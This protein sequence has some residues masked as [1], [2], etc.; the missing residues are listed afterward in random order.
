[1]MKSVKVEAK[2]S[3]LYHSVSCLNWVSEKD[4]FHDSSFFLVFELN[5]LL[6]KNGSFLK[7]CHF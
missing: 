1:M 5:D 6:L 2:H 4:G 7:V 3:E